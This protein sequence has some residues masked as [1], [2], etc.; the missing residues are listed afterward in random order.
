VS[1]VPQI[2]SLPVPDGLEGERVD[3]AIARMF[4]FSRTKAAELAADGKVLLDGAAVGKSDRVMAGSWMEVEIP[5]PPAPV[6]IVAERIDN[7]RIV[8]DDEH[9]V[10][11]DKPVGVAAH[12]S[13]G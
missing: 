9:L 6:Q 7:M 3:A 13:P 2:R 4:G 12:P 10:V 11:V 1:T 8:H 5:A